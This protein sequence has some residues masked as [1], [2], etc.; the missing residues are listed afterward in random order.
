[1]DR[2]IDQQRVNTIIEKRL[3]QVPQQVKSFFP[4]VLR[5]RGL[6]RVM[7]PTNT[8]LMMAFISHAENKRIMKLR[9]MAGHPFPG[10]IT[11]DPSQKAAFRIQ[12][13]R[14]T[15]IKDCT[16]KNM[17]AISLGTDST[18]ILENHTQSINSAELGP[19][20]Y[21]VELAYIVSFGPDIT[22]T[23]IYDHI[24]DLIAYSIGQW[25]PRRGTTA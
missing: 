6:T 7:L 15:L 25:R 18:I 4:L 23:N 9:R 12:N 1:M 17:Y 5:Q 8:Y 11:S 22:P 14:F 19:Y 2:Q 10:L 24:N 16:V 3:L 21:L 20:K 13:S